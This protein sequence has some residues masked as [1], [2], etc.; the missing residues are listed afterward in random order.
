[1][2]PNED[3]GETFTNVLK[4][5]VLA[6]G[7]LEGDTNQFLGDHNQ[8]SLYQTGVGKSKW[9]DTG[10]ATPIQGILG[11]LH[12]QVDPLKER[13]S[14]VYKEGDVLYI[15]GF[16]RGAA[17]AR[18]LASQLNMDG[19]KLANGPV[20][21]KPKI[22]LLGCWDTVAMQVANNVGGVIHDWW[23]ME[24][25]TSEV[26]GEINGELGEIVENA[27][28]NVSIDDN[29]MWYQVTYPPTLMDS[30]N[31]RVLEV[32][33]PGTH[34]DVGGKPYKNGL[35]NGSFEFMQDSAKKLGLKFLESQ[36]ISEVALIF[37]G[38][39]WL[40]KS[41]FDHEPNCAD[42]VNPSRPILLWPRPLGVKKK[43]VLAPEETAKI[44]VYY[45]EHL[46]ARKDDGAKYCINEYMK[47]AKYTIVG[48][49][50]EDKS[51]RN[52][53]LKQ[54]LDEE[55]EIDNNPNIVTIPRWGK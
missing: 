44:H 28:H 1:M 7:A 26:L 12:T 2:Q 20:I 10:V 32:W 16:S 50:G 3:K 22:E 45:L 18:L 42:Q 30:S 43:N 23:N 8:I 17:S 19:L 55:F 49:L 53:E 41:D 4:F 34:G 52:D 38:E 5:H 29:R 6:G 25:P 39:L 21:M 54:L 51:D 31:D 9:L 37:E 13:L 48:S 14:R 47:D 40:H 15:F 35:S 27:V 11:E 33:F 36:D 24:W 46:K